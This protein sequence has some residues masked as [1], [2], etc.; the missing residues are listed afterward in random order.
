MTPLEYADALRRRS[1]NTLPE[2]DTVSKAASRR[3]ALAHPDA[4]RAR[5]VNAL[6]VLAGL[7]GPVTLGP[8]CHAVAL[9][10]ADLRPIGLVTGTLHE[11]LDDR[12][13]HMPQYTW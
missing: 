9:E 5:L 12:G 7:E 10:A 8:E 2:P 11:S 6:H 1:G 13:L 3:L 4:T